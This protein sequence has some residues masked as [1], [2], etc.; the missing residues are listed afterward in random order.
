M[1]EFGRGAIIA[2][3]AGGLPLS[4]PQIRGAG[5]GGGHDGGQRKYTDV[6]RYYLGCH[7]RKAETY[8]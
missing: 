8:Q 3:R 1:R 7:G 4:V 2:N 5:G 6:A